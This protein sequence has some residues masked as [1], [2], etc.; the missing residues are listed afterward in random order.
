MGYRRM[1]FV[2]L[3]GSGG[4][5]LRFL[6]RDFTEWCL[7]NGWFDAEGTK[8]PK[9]ELPFGVQFLNI[10]T[11]AV[12]D[13]LGAGGPLLADREYRG[14][15][16]GGMTMR[17]LIA[18]VDAGD[19][20]GE[21]LVGWRVSPNTRVRV[22]DAG[23]QMRAVGRS[24]SRAYA[25]SV[26]NALTNAL[27]AVQSPRATTE[28]QE[29]YA[30]VHNSTSVGISDD[31]ASQPPVTVF[32]SSLAGGTGA[33]LIFDVVDIYRSLEPDLMDLT[34]GIWF[35]PD[36]FPESYGQGLRPNALAAISEMLNGAWW[37]PQ[38]STS[39]RGAAIP[40]RDTRALE[41]VAGLP[42]TIDRSG[43]WANYLVGQT[44][45]A[46]QRMD[47]DGR[48][49]EKVGGALLSWIVD[50]ELN[51]RLVSK[52]LGNLDSTREYERIEL[53]WNY[54]SAAAVMDSSSPPIFDALGF[55]RVSLGTRYFTRYSIERLTRRVADHLVRAHID[56][57][58]ARSE[59]QA[60]GLSNPV[61]V[62]EYIARR[63]YAGFRDVLDVMDS[64][65]EPDRRELLANNRENTEQEEQLGSIYGRVIESA[66][67][68]AVLQEFKNAKADGLIQYAEG[69]NAMSVGEWADQ[70]LPVINEDIRSALRR[71]VTDA[72][73]ERIAEWAEKASERTV[74]RAEEAVG[75]FGLEIAQGIIDMLSLEIR[76]VIIPA[77]KRLEEESIF[78]GSRNSVQQEF[79]ESLG[80]EFG[81]TRK[82]SAEQVADAIRAS[83]D[84]VSFDAS[85][86]VLRRA[87][88]MIGRYRDGLLRPI[89]TQ[90]GAA[91]SRLDARHAETKTFPANND[92]AT[93]PAHLLPPESE[94]TV[95]DNEEFGNI[96]GGMLLE[97]FKGS[98]PAQADD[99]AVAELAS[100]S[101]V[102]RR[103][104]A[105]SQDDPFRADYERAQ[106]INLQRT[107]SVGLDLV[108]GRDV[109]SPASVEVR[110]DI[111][112]ILQRSE[113][114]VKRPRFP[115]GDFA[116]MDLRSY[117]EGDK[118]RQQRVLAK[119]REAV[120]TAQPL[121]ELY[122]DTV[123]TIHN[124][125]LD[126]AKRAHFSITKV[127]FSNSSIEKEVRELLRS[128]I[129]ANEEAQ[130]Q[131]NAIEKVLTDT[132]E[133]PYIDIVSWLATPVSPIV[134]K[135][136][137]EPLVE[138][139]TG[140]KDDPASR[141]KYWRNRRA[142]P[143]GEFIPLPQPQ[144]IAALRGWYT[145]RVLGFIDVGDRISPPF[146]I[147]GG[148]Q[149][150][151]PRW[152]SFPQQLLSEVVDPNDLGAVVLES[153]SI[154]MAFAYRTRGQ[155][156]Q[157]YTELIKLGMSEPKDAVSEVFEY[158]QP[159]PIIRQWIDL[160]RI[161]LRVQGESPLTSRLTPESDA[162]T[163]K[164]QLVNLF[165]SNREGFTSAYKDYFDKEVLR[166]RD[167]LNAPPLWPGIY[168]QIDTAHAMLLAGIEAYSPG[169]G[170]AQTESMGPLVG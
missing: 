105:M 77:L 151:D 134:I 69:L 96:F 142:R 17:S 56:S 70:L 39:T 122:D 99:A 58:W 158:P 91:S 11:P 130:D 54:G 5:A 83:V 161:E 52:V 45:I 46:G 78:T 128:R 126:E 80:A 98:S 49:F 60:S 38:S 33:G 129:Y 51:D 26:Q 166:S 28:M 48:L 3:G 132:A 19:P 160:G 112:H 47:S 57:D 10:D 6:K 36:A 109:E 139:W 40:M 67:E 59:K 114:W 121:V 155:S 131:E 153:L 88:L 170:D 24:I 53:P 164:Q 21:S 73:Y 162:D 169:T 9:S 102:R 23:G 120:A 37:L 65:S 30:H 41:S 72:L 66:L 29:L 50:P 35:T 63:R 79:F 138:S 110:F 8:E 62:S 152:I 165:T 147:L 20:R 27:N 163:R 146:R 75:V 86:E 31:P 42:N 44:N 16:S 103:L 168:L 145:G 149:S 32:I 15:V 141:R 92:A 159:H 1:L 137:M 117:A 34:V 2:G 95:I 13:G 157:P 89:I 68:P 64:L 127:P 116:A 87:G 4:K 140:A 18:Q 154:A 136:L 100:G 106:V 113:L 123:G 93:P 115:F 55:S 104:S 25:A 90:L 156:L 94:S 101:F 84:A 167:T 125:M 133:L 61:Q 150:E 108:G 7:Q 143:L 71:G 76:D 12:Q 119:L 144:L 14:L 107:W 111:E 43:V 22:S 81:D 85:A 74:A 97:T 135:T 82:V 124:K 118:G 148:S